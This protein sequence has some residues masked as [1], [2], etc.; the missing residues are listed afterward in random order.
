MD[1]W[2]HVDVRLHSCYSEVRLNHLLSKQTEKIT[3]ST[4][5]R[6]LCLSRSHTA[7]ASMNVNVDNSDE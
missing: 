5:T 2:D 7:S 3:Q 6:G 4:P 1:D